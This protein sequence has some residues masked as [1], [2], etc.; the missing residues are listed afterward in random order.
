[1]R[2]LLCACLTEVGWHSGAASY[3]LT[4]PGFRP[5]LWLLSVRMFIRCPRVFPL[6]SGFLPPP[7]NM[8]VGGLA[9]LLST[10]REYTQV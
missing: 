10:S 4:A 7:H 5:D 3:C 1:M 6:F 2:V 9:L 8:L